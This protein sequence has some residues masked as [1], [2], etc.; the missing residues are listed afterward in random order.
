VLTISD[1][2]SD[3]YSFPIQTLNQIRNRL[4]RGFY[5][6]AES[7]GDVSLF[8]YDNDTFIVESFLPDSVDIRLSLDPRY[9]K[10]RDLISG[11]EFEGK[12]GG[13]PGGFFGF[14]AGSEK[15]LTYPVRIKPHSY[16]VFSAAPSP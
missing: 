13:A 4:L 10:I 7:P 14:G 9:G 16:R 12:S 15:R 2:C 6:R 3:L 1:N 5:V 8:V 11:Q